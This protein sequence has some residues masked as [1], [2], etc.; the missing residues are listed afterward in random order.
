MNKDQ[1]YALNDTLAEFMDR[2][3]MPYDDAVLD[4]AVWAV[5]RVFE[6]AE[7]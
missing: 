6:R 7:D 2:H 5:V 3:G 4:D 1:V